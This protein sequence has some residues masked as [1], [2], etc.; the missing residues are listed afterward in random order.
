MYIAVN[1]SVWGRAD[2]IG[3]M[4]A[5]IRKHLYSIDL[6]DA[7]ELRLIS[8]KP[9]SV[10]FEDGTYYISQGSVLTKNPNNAVRVNE[11]HMEELI[12]RLTKSSLYA[13]KD[14]IK[15]GYIT[16][17]GGHRAGLA[18]TA[19]TNNGCVEF[20]KNISAVNIRLA[21]E[22]RGAADAIINQCTPACS[23]L[24][25]S[26]PGCGKTTVLRDLAR[27]LSKKGI[28]VAIADER[29]ELAAMHNGRSAFDLG[30]TT[31]VLD[32][33]PKHEAMMMLLRSM[34]PEVIITDEIGTQKDAEA[35]RTV[36]NS[37]VAVAASVHGR[38]MKQLMRRKY[39]S[40][41]VPMFDTVVVLSR[42]CG[43]GTI[44]EIIKND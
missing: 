28:S 12:E 25:V 7:E 1:E 19:I 42:R 4:P 18:G 5:H 38:D 17:E 16:I 37:G 33:C 3:I 40:E 30:N 14:E 11:R 39:I 44:E 22:V 15:N 6:N 34:S 2:V 21:H 36:M 9:F 24:L 23:I 27:G 35:I 31:A 43:A 13:V 26:P 32:N 20:I 8:G 10:R 29:C 41:L